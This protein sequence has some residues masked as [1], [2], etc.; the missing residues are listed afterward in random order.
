MWTNEIR[1]STE[2]DTSNTTNV[3]K[4]SFNSTQ[5]QYK[6]IVD[7]KEGDLDSLRKRNFINDKEY[8]SNLNNTNIYDQLTNEYDEWQTTTYFI[9]TQLARRHQC[10]NIIDLRCGRAEALSKV[11][12]EFNPIGV[13]F[14]NN[15]EYAKQK[16]PHINFVEVTFAC[17]FTKTLN[18]K[19][20][21]DVLKNSVVVSA[22]IIEHIRDPQKCYFDTLKY[23]LR[24]A[25]ALVLS[26][27][28]RNYIYRERTLQKFIKGPPK[29]RNRVREHTLSELELMLAANGMYPALGG[30]ICNASNGCPLG[31]VKA[32]QSY[33]KSLVTLWNTPVR[34]TWMD[35][36][37]NHIKIT[38][39]LVVHS[40]INYAIIRYTLDALV[41]Q[42]IDIVVLSFSNFEVETLKKYRD[43]V[44]YSQ[45]VST[46]SDVENQIQFHISMTEGYSTED[47][48][49]VV[50]G[51]EIFT[52][53]RDPYI[54][55]TR[56]IR[57]FISHV[58]T[59]RG[60]YNAIAISSV[61]LGSTWGQNYP[62]KIHSKETWVGGSFKSF[63]PVN[64]LKYNTKIWKNTFHSQHKLT[65]SFA[66]AKHGYTLIESVNFVNKKIFP[67]NV[68][69]WRMHPQLSE[70][71]DTVLYDLGL[72]NMYTYQLAFLF[73]ENNR[74][75][76]FE[77]SWI[78]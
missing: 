20:G 40:G 29:D 42:N 8:I 43:N 28:D 25:P 18:T 57:D 65:F 19:L 77:L 1:E 71:D 9:A 23:A 14:R 53:I 13:D 12:P 61:F 51:N 10:Q 66:V 59:T 11:F 4:S 33:Q 58:G 15:L 24:H 2:E 44:I 7:L 21:A 56:S 72:Q 74:R 41:K 27:S 73:S 35:N 64:H 55:S 46:I 49:M 68:V 30:W 38:A 36:V 69:G 17:A 78:Y 48:F 37:E 60:S 70:F 3:H 52:T 45:V 16:Y 54:N 50:D 26:A 34:Q 47:W 22:D 6:S 67:Y 76:I 39:F 31:F 62:F 75:D 32:E 5:S 63:T